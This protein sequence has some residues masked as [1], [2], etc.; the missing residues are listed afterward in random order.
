MSKHSD[1]QP[2]KTDQTH[3]MMYEKIIGLGEKS[4]RK[5][6]YPLLR[7]KINE[8]EH[9]IGERKKK[10]AELQKNF[11]NKNILNS[12]LKLS[13]EAIPFE[14]LLKLALEHILSL[15]WIGDRGSASFFFFDDNPSVLE[16]KSTLSTPDFPGPSCS[17]VP[18]GNCLCGKAALEGTTFFG[19]HGSGETSH[20]HYCVPIRFE[21]KTLGIICIGLPENHTYDPLEEEMLT[22]ISNTLAGIIQRNRMMDEKTKLEAQ[23]RQTQ[24]LEAIGTLAGGI[25]HDFNNLLTPILGY[26][27]M[28][29]QDAHLDSRIAKDLSEV[30]KAAS[31]AKDLVRQ[32]LTL[33]RQSEREVKPLQVHL[34]VTEALKLLRSTIPST[35]Q[36]KTK[37]EVSRMTV[38]ADPAQIHQ[39]I[40]NLCTNAYHAMKKTGGILAVSLKSLKIDDGLNQE[41]SFV[42]KPGHYMVLE[43]SD[44]GVGMTKTVMEKI[45][46]PY[47]TTKSKEEGTGLGLSVV[48]GIIKSYGGNISVYSE[49]GRGTTFRIYLPSSQETAPEGSAISTDPLPTGSEHVLVVDDEKAIVEMISSMLTH[50]GY[51][52][53]GCVGSL[54]ALGVFQ[55][56][57]N[58]FSMVI[59]D[60]TM[61]HLNGAQ[62]A[63]ALRDIRP[64][65]PMVV[66]T[67]FSDLIN[68][69]KASA[70]GFQRFIMKPIIMREL[71]MAVR[72]V[73]DGK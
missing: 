60:M 20:A 11:E 22:A 14:D 42:L 18:T 48:Q 32:I 23:L 69:E 26:T 38:L 41:D 70:L 21:H 31:L 68:P 24:K 50:R 67:G 62:L 12:L 52:V 33:S 56:N 15:S 72:D 73:L 4:I 5:S 44:T 9:E 7:Q 6:Y 54:K 43:V 30:V 8:L 13:L 36:I 55:E 10:E 17:S 58:A 49:P 2:E 64:D 1:E 28:I 35:I 19:N 71:C 57:P 3:G 63:K 65:I 66:C 53:T 51:T 45:F 37:V 25:A 27:E 34:V 29:L 59:T 40:M 61:P 39:I 16:L 46:D 47:F